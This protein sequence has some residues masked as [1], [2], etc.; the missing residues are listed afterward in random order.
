MRMRKPA[1]MAVSSATSPTDSINPVNIP[2]HQHVDAERCHA[3]IDE[4]GERQRVRRATNSRRPERQRRDIQM[5]GIDESRSTPQRGARPPFEHKRHDL[6]RRAGERLRQR[7]TLIG[8]SSAPA[9]RVAGAVAVIAMLSGVVTI[10]TGP[11]SSVENTRA[12]GG[13]RSRRSNS[14]RVSGRP[15]GRG[16]RSAA[17]RR[18]ARF[19]SRRR[20]HR[21]P[22]AP[23]RV[24]LRSSELSA[25]AAPRCAATRLSRLV[26]A[27]MMT[28]GRRRS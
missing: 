14:T 22:P 12:E 9:A 21:P 10:I 16:G 6:P 26:A 17:D 4:R 2:F 5:D 1:S 23:L 19:P 18:P 27:F 3:A 15:G 8:S 24:P 11:A 25:S 20:W 28:N 7:S 13:I